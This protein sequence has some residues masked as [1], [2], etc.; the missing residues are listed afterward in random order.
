MNKRILEPG[1]YDLHLFILP[2]IAERDLEN[3]VKFRLPG[4][5]P[6]SLSEDTPLE[7][8]SYRKNNG[9]NVLLFIGRKDLL[10]CI[11]GTNEQPILPYQLI[12]AWQKRSPVDCYMILGKR[13]LEIYRFKD[14]CPIDARGLKKTSS[15]DDLFKEEDL[16][17]II[18]FP[19]SND[20][21]GHA[22]VVDDL[23]VEI[24]A[25]QFNSHI[26]KSFS[27]QKTRHKKALGKKRFILYGIILL[28]L[29]SLNLEVRIMER[30]KAL[31]NLKESVQFVQSA[32][33]KSVE[34][35]KIRDDMLMDLE[36][37]LEKPGIDPYI[38]FS[39]LYDAVGSEMRI[40]NITV[41]KDGFRGQGFSKDPFLLVEML[42]TKD[43][44][45]SVNV[46]NIRRID[47][48]GEVSFS[49]SG[50]YKR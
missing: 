29:V 41:N 50:S 8:F 3:T 44:F 33:I 2:K 1:E 23:S 10:T 16:V 13:F 45:F 7:I 38:F 25:D 32:Y 37:N 39:D 35:R 21:K 46:Y 19:E 48:S 43:A 36:K 17:R 5:F 28:L 30:E 26:Y 27:I 14:N 49:V 9:W 20:F 31:A 40:R 4:V 11:E 15:T 18:R 12:T 34:L 42:K 6:G 22:N 47:E 24:L